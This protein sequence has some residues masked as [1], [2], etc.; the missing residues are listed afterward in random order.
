MR[1][2][3][4]ILSTWFNRLRSRN[5]GRSSGIGDPTGNRGSSANVAPPVPSTLLLGFGRTKY[6]ERRASEAHHNGNASTSQA[7]PGLRI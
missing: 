1:S 3:G 7:V 2:T 5:D 4:C 6:S